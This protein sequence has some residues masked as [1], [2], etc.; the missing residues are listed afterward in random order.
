MLNWRIHCIHVG[1]MELDKSFFVYRKHM[2]QDIAAPIF[3]WLLVRSGG[4]PILVDTGGCDPATAATLHFPL[5][6]TPDQ[7]PAAALQKYGFQ[8][9]DIKLV[10]NTHLHWD[11]CYNNALFRG[12]RI[13]VQR[14]ELEYARHPLPPHLASYEVGVPG[15]EPPFADIPFEVIDGD[16][17]LAPGVHL[18]AAPGHTPGSQV[19]MVETREGIY[20]IASDNIPLYDNWAPLATPYWP[21]GYFCDLFVYYRSLEK[22]A[23]LADHVLPGHDP[24][25]VGKSF[26]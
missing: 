7:E 1:T 24:S 10:V 4:D 22:I 20:C 9:P 17:E 2:G 26:G 21:D 3:M 18:M 23:G 19:V 12:A 5:T 8:P 11:H 25:L 16:R 14:A 6:R 13:M 15:H